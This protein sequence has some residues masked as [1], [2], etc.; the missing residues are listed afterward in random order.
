MLELLF[1]L[2]PIAAAYGWYMG[3]R[4][5]RIDHQQSTDRRSRN[6]VAGINFLLSDQPDKAVDLFIG[7]ES[8]TGIFNTH[9]RECTGIVVGDR[10]GYGRIAG[11]GK[12]IPIGIINS[13]F[14][15]EQTG[16]S[17]EAGIDRCF[18]TDHDTAPVT[19][20]GIRGC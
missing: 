12:S 1:L 6:Y 8:V 5:V 7:L 17:V 2:L 10:S 13:P 11:T 15:L 18:T 16:C 20:L 3:R 19:G 14:Y 9:I 4:G